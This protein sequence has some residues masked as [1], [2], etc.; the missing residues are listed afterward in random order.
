MKYA[1]I[2]VLLVASAF[3]ADEPNLDQCVADPSHA[4]YRVFQT[5]NIWTFLKLDTRTGL[6]WQ[7]QWGD[8][9]GMIAVNWKPLV[10]KEGATAGRF[11]LCP[12]KN[13]FNFILLDQDDGDIWSV[14][15]SLDEKTRY[16]SRITAPIVLADPNPNQHLAVDPL[17]TH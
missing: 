2:L 13:I 4:T 7:V 10:I 17:A 6:I 15:W 12:T 1:A 5:K 3:A 16:I 8:N 9:A 14:Q 11:T